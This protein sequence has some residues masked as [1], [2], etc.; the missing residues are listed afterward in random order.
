M[1][2]EYIVQVTGYN[3]ATSVQPYML[4]VESE[5]PRLAPTCQPRFPGLSFGAATGVDLA[6]IPADTDTLFLANGPQLGAAGGLGVLD[7]FTSQHLN[8]LRGTGNPSAVVRLEND[9]AVR[10]AYTAWNLEP[11]SS[12]RANAVVRAITD[13]VRTIRNARPAVRNLVLLG[14]DKALPFARLDDL[15]TIANE[16]DYAWTFAREDD[17]YGAMFEH[18]VLSDDPYA[19]TDPIPYLQRQLFVPQLAVGRLVETPAQITGALDRFVA[20][21]GDLDPASARTTGYDFLK[22]GAAALPP[23]LPASSAHGSRPRTRR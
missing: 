3:G 14:N 11:C 6:S 16:A 23:R 12:A 15:T 5:A 20:F 17:L 9:P 13:V 7:W 2:G 22:D 10:A 8:Q 18:R 21:G 4:R 19:T 1:P